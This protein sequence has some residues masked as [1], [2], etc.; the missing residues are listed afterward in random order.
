MIQMPDLITFGIIRRPYNSTKFWCIVCSSTW[1][2]TSMVGLYSHLL[3][4]IFSHFCGFFLAYCETVKKEEIIGALLNLF[5]LLQVITYILMHSCILYIIKG[6]RK[7]TK[8]DHILS[9]W[10]CDRKLDF[11]GWLSYFRW[12]QQGLKYAWDHK[13]QVGIGL[14]F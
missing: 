14:S 13:E 3:E 9:S 5:S 6:V 7:W 8:L 11:K 2:M 12:G 4:I 10:P 1:N